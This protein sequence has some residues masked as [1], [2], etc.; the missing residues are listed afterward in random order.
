MNIFTS[1]IEN[2]LFIDST[3]K[4]YNIFVNSV[5]YNTYPLVYSYDMDSVTI[6]EIFKQFKTI[7]RIG[8]V[9]HGSNDI[10]IFV[11]NEKF[12][13]SKNLEFLL[14]IIFSYQ[15]SNIDF[16]AC[17]TMKYDEWI[18][19]YKL[20]NENTKETCIIGASSNNIGN[21]NYIMESTNENI[22]YIY[23]TNDIIKYDNLLTYPNYPPSPPFSLAEFSQTPTSLVD[24]LI[25]NRPISFSFT[26]S[27]PLSGTVSFYTITITKSLIINNIN[28]NT[29]NF[30]QNSPLNGTAA[31]PVDVTL[32][33]FI[34][35][36]NN[37]LLNYRYTCYVTATNSE[38]QTS[39]P[40]NVIELIITV[41]PTAVGPGIK[42]N[43]T[44][45]EIITATT[46]DKLHIN[47]TK[48]I[49]LGW[50]LEGGITFI[51]PVNNIPNYIQ[52]MTL[53]LNNVNE[54]SVNALK[55]E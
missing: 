33:G 17:N 51:P 45:Y 21:S 42:L 13:S 20:L 23:F 38:G 2:V 46:L 4:D 18:Y 40:S 1:D 27:A 41:A 26:W 53:N 39:L 48:K 37:G 36:T 9:C 16:I 22:M 31:L 47:I 10:S 7:K 49:T 15:V 32:T 35:T 54:F 55:I 29:I 52:G 43:N 30:V 24:T 6:L 5:N 25:A 11:N 44:I 19:Y 14:K 3:L 28:T 34:N 12:S 8:V 50:V